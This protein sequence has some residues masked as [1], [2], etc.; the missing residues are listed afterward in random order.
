MSGTTTQTFNTGFL[1][2]PLPVPRSQGKS[3]VPGA[4]HRPVIL[5]KGLVQLHATPLA[6]GEVCL[7]HVPHHTSLCP[8]NLLAQR[9]TQVQKMQ[10]AQAEMAQAPR[11]S[12][13]S[14]CPF[15]HAGE[16]GAGARRGR[17]LKTGGRNSLVGA[18]PRKGF[19]NRQTYVQTLPLT[20]CVNL[21]KLSNL[22][23]LRH[24]H[25]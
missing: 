4:C 14:H 25:L 15:Q 18:V 13:S 3:T 21:D 7:P 1:K 8:A 12:A 5:P 16:R 17:G 19:G 10:R 6:L 20:S 2:C 24:L 9:E 22:S 23:G 11:C